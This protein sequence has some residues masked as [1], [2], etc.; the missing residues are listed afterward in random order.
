MINLENMK[1]LY[2][3]LTTGLYFHKSGVYDVNCPNMR[4]KYIARFYSA[5]S[6]LIWLVGGLPWRGVFLL[7]GGSDI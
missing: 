3:L 7:V 5:A 4:K 1:E 6:C 2:F